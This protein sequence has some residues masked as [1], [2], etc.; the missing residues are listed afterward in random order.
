M[1]VAIGFF[2]YI[3]IYRSCYIYLKLAKLTHKKKKTN[4]KHTDFSLSKLILYRAYDLCID[5]CYAP[6]LYQSNIRD[7]SACLRSFS[8][9]LAFWR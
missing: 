1:Y 8:K 2:F 9:I 4:K 6:A 5:Y 7:F 3:H